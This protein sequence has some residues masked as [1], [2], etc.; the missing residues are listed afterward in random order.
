[1]RS[2]LIALALFLPFIYPNAS[3]AS[4]INL[5]INDETVHV[6]FASQPSRKDLNLSASLLHHEDD[7]DVYSIGAF[8]QSPINNRQ[9]LHGAL[10]GRLYYMDADGPDG[11][12]LGLGGEIGFKIP[13]IPD[14]SLHAELYY[15]PKVLT[16]NDVDRFIDTS[17]RIK[18]RVLEQ[19]S[20]YLG[21]RKQEVDIEHG[22]KVDIDKGGHIGISLQF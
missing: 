16:F 3:T 9:D 6:A 14:L 11:Y 20:I 7:G 17:I 2:K 12:G 13:Q 22:G 1:M 19:G 4:Q 21:Y 18:Y 10:G 15:A 8:V 5:D